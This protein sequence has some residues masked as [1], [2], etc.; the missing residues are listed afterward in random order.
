MLQAD[1][2]IIIIFITIDVIIDTIFVIAHV[3]DIFSNNLS[4]PQ[5]NV[6]F[7]FEGAKK[8]SIQDQTIGSIV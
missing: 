2:S 3:I 4:Q 6:S 7:C 1:I 5:A 8:N